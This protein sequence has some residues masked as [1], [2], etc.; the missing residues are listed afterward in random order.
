MLNQ[1]PLFVRL[2]L[3]SFLANL[4]L[5]SINSSF[6]KPASATDNATSGEKLFKA[7]CSGCHLNGKNLIRPNKPIIG[8]SKLQSKESLKAFIESPPPPMPK[9][10]NITEKKEQFDAL[11]SYVTS[12]M[13]K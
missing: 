8:S 3:I 4:F 10:K 6:S 11:Y 12:L 2:I 1:L 7:N 5:A 9:F 13:G